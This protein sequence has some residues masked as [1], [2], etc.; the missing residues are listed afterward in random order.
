VDH[1]FDIKLASYRQESELRTWLK[2]QPADSHQWCR[3]Q[4]AK[5]SLRLDATKSYQAEA[6]D[7]MAKPGRYALKWANGTAKTTTAAMWVHWFM[8]MYPPTTPGGTRVVTSAGSFSQLVQQLWREMHVWTERANWTAEP[9]M[10]PTAKPGVMSKSHIELAPNWVCMARAA[11]RADTFE[12]V[13]GDRVAVVVDEAK[14][15]REEIFGAIRRILRG[16]PNGQ[17]WLILLSSPGSPSGPFWEHTAGSKSDQFQVMSLSAY[18]SSRIPLE[19]IGQDSVDLGEDSPLFV[20]MDLG[21]FPDEGEDVLIALSWVDAAI[22]KAVDS[23]PYR[24]L[25]VDVAR[26]GQDNTSMWR[27][28]GRKCNKAAGYNGQ[29][30]AWTTGKVAELHRAERFHAIAVDDTGI[31][32]A[33][34]DFMRAN[35]DFKG[36]HIIP[37]NFGAK[38]EENPERYVNMKTEIYFGLREDLRAGAN[39]PFSAGIG[40]S[41]PDDKKM[42]HQLTCQHFI[43][44]ERQRYRVEPRDVLKARGERSPD[45]AD[46]IALAD[47]AR[48]RMSKRERTGATKGIRELNEEGATRGLVANLFH[49]GF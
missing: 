20:A 48:G 36:C 10:L 35:K 1:H 38:A 12:G 26:K 19:T 3:Q 41:L 29:D 37:V 15:V 43:F 33:L 11:D 42:K 27:M 6:L 9:F 24:V 32:G 40:L 22:D 8:S 31:G 21:E 23:F 14:A 5:G 18:E 25:G 30:L 16:N 13:H 4:L 17:F 47:W 44:D 28:Y 7:A 45:D 2:H 46:A 39:S 34:T 49:D